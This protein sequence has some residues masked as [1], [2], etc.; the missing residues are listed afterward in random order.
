MRRRKSKK[1]NYIPPT[2]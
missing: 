1:R 2:S